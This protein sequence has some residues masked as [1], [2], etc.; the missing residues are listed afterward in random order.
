MGGNSLL[1]GGYDE[2]PA[3]RGGRK[4]VNSIASTSNLI[5][6]GYGEDAMTEMEKNFKPYSNKVNRGS[7]LY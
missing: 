3:Q 2:A 4:I 7:L 6:G 1:T 5:L